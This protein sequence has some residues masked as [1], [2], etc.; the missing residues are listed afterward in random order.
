[1]IMQ[2]IKYLKQNN[3]F[4]LRRSM[5]ISFDGS[6]KRTNLRIWGRILKLLRFLTN[7]FNRNWGR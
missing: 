1:M 2:S 7:D 3:Q 6:E 4:Q 5:K